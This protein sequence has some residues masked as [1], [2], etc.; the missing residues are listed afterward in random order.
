MLKE[1]VATAHEFMRMIGQLSGETGARA[2][3][4]YL[5]AQGIGNRIEPARDG[6]WELW[7]EAE[8]QIDTAAALLNE[9]QAKERGRSEEVLR[10]GQALPVC[11][12]CRFSDRDSHHSQ[13]G[14]MVGFGFRRGYQADSVDVH[15]AV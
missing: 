3:G 5:Y 11:R 9:Y 8:D 13:R 4:D 15:F 6:T 12:R 10:S 14:H 2:F 7:V 1:A